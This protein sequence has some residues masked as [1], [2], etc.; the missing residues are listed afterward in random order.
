MGAILRPALLIMATAW[1]SGMGR[2]VNGAFQRSQNGARGAIAYTGL[3]SPTIYPAGGTGQNGVWANG[4]DFTGASFVGDSFGC[5]VIYDGTFWSKFANQTSL[6]YPTLPISPT[7]YGVTFIS[8]TFPNDPA[9]GSSISPNDYF[10]A[11]VTAGS[12]ATPSLSYSFGISSKEDSDSP[13]VYLPSHTFY[14]V[15]QSGGVMTSFGGVTLERGFY[16]VLASESIPTSMRV[17]VKQSGAGGTVYDITPAG[18]ITATPFFQFDS[19]ALMGNVTFKMRFTVDTSSIA[20]SPA[21]SPNAF[22]A[23]A[24]MMRLR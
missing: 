16:S 3:G 6:T 12:F 4:P 2:G 7:N 14:S 23:G 9:P 5:E 20:G 1:L 19:I 18:G 8:Q 15:I 11:I 17:L 10:I 24:A 22:G 13:V 21:T